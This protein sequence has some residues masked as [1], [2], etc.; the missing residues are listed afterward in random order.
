MRE[1]KARGS[2]LVIY[3]DGTLYHIDL[4]RADNIPPNI[5]LV[6]AAERV[7]T[8]AKRF[9]KI[10]FVNRNKSRPEFYTVAG[11]YKKIPM[12]VMSTG[13]GTDNIEIVMNELHALFEYEYE[14]DEWSRTPAKI[15]IIR[16]GTSGTSLKEI[17]SGAIAISRYSIGLDN[18]GTYY[19]PLKRDAA[20][21]NIEKIFLETRLGKLHSSAYA[22]PASEA[23]IRALENS[24]K[25]NGEK[26][27]WLV[28]G[29]TTASPGFFAPEG[30]AIGRIKPAL[31][32]DEFI[33]TIIGFE[34]KG[35]KIVNHEM[36]TS[37]L[38]RLSNE[39][40]GYNAGAICLILDNLSTD[41]FIDKEAAAKRMDVCIKIALDAMVELTDNLN[42]SA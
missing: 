28:S 6:G 42:K 37:A 24:A 36:E 27:P 26:E 15:N 16:I 20:A 3:P 39:I 23:I 32:F 33:N 29:I 2:Q 25:N 10:T 40:L 18:I 4:K 9:E 35:F 11:V 8:I 22:T 31:S 38:F 1:D 41:D 14:K 12:A 19:P 7:D 13:I 5:F 34:A 21:E 17:S 30:R